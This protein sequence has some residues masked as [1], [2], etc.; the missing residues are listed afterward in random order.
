MYY[1]AF[2]DIILLVIKM[3]KTISILLSLVLLLAGCLTVP[4]SAKEQVELKINDITVYAGDEFEINLFISDNSRLSGAVID[5]NYDSKLLEFVSSSKGAILDDSATISIK[6]F[7]DKSYVRFTYMAPSSSITSEGILFSV[8]FKALENAVGKT[9]I[10]ISVPSAGDFVN[11]DLEKLTFSVDNAT[12]DIINTTY[13]STTESTE[14]EQSETVTS[15]VTET[16]ATVTES[17]TGSDTENEKNFLIPAVCLIT[18]GFVIIIG[19]VVYLVVS[20][21]KKGN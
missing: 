19:A 7:K 2:Y 11:S 16:E 18:V 5:M 4:V 9:Y 15:S 8:K 20:K 14:S 21:K 13:Q 10:K 3:K 12:V 6:D 1:Y 17:N